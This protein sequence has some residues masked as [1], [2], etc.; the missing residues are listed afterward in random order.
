MSNRHS[1]FPLFISWQAN[2]L[3]IGLSY[4]QISESFNIRKIF[5]QYLISDYRGLTYVYFWGS[6]VYHLDTKEFL[7][8]FLNKGLR[9]CRRR[10][11]FSFYPFVLYAHFSENQRL[12]VCTNLLLMPFRKI[13]ILLWNCLLA[14]LPNMKKYWPL[15]ARSQVKYF[16]TNSISMREFWTC[17]IINFCL[18][19]TR[20]GHLWNS[21]L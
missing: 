13:G 1:Y 9:Y 12:L 20:Q 21:L 16:G 10:E 5:P 4:F 18:Q 7:T 8:I 19:I 2:G 14:P 17:S 6:P 3:F 15:M 11:I